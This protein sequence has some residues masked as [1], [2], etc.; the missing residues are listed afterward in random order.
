MRRMRAKWGR[1][2]HFEMKDQKQLQDGCL[3]LACCVQHWPLVENTGRRTSALCQSHQQTPAGSRH[4][5]CTRHWCPCRRLRLAR[6]LGGE[7]EEGEMEKVSVSLSFTFCSILR[8]HQN[9]KWSYDDRHKQRCT[10]KTKQ[11]HWLNFFKP[12]ESAEAQG[13]GVRGPLH[14]AHHVHVGH[15]FDT[16][17]L[18]WKQQNSNKCFII[19]CNTTITTQSAGVG[20]RTYRRGSRSLLSWWRGTGCLGTSPRGWQSWSD[21]EEE[22]KET[23]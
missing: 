20:P 10:K 1:Q 11:A 9:I 3:V 22:E 12:T 4:V 14:V 13:A 8:Q 16:R 17:C 15:V 6:F 5:T 23:P 21:P 18:P 7:E 2:M 19:F